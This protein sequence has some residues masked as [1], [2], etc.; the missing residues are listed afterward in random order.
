MFNGA[1]N[2]NQ[3]LDHWDIYNTE[4][5]PSNYAIRRL[6]KINGIFK[7]CP[8]LDFELTNWD[9]KFITDDKRFCIKCYFEGSP[10]MIQRF[11]NRNEKES[12]F[13]RLKR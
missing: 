4:I 8:N 10:K 9:L 13:K 7:N 11:N 5:D 12:K 2:F 3:N 1:S 6:E